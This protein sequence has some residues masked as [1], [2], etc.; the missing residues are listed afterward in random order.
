VPRR[1]V[2][3]PLLA[4]VALVAI[5]GIGY[6]VRA[7]DSHRSTPNSVTTRASSPVPLSSLPVPLSS[8]PA[9]AAQTVELIRRGGPFPY[10]RNDGAVFHNAE[11]ELPGAPDGYYREYTVPTPGLSSRGARRIIVGAHGEYYY[12]GDHYTSFVRVDVSG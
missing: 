7:A 12:T 1:R 4:L 5:S 9:E 3:R 8:L 2:R 6:G 11:H 10:P